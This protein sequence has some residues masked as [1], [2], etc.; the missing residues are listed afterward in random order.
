VTKRKKARVAMA[1]VKVMRVVDD[2]EGENGKAMAM[3]T[4]MAGKWTVTA[5][6][7]AMAMATKAAGKWR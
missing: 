5:R 6:K 2:E 1:M 3:A 7:R 4:R